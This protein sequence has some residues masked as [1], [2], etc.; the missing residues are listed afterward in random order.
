MTL[1]LKTQGDPLAL[2]PT[3]E[4]A[5]DDIQ[6]ELPVFEGQSIVEALYSINGFLPFQI[7]AS[8]AA[9]M[10]GLGLTVALIGLYGLI[11]YAVSQRVQEIG[12]RMALGATRGSVFEM[13]YRQSMRIVAVGLGI[14]VA[15]ALLGG[16]SVWTL[17]LCRGL[18][19]P[20]VTTGVSVPVPRRLR[21]RCV[22]GRGAKRLVG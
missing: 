15:G 16:D 19:P 17:I 12:V 6:P 5:I 4:D 14:D 7:G 13:I 9:M 8:L 3:A 1:Q 18:G 2:A 21:S 10:G 11:S 20:K 22:D